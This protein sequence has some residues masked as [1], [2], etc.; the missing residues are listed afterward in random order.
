MSVGHARHRPLAV[1]LVGCGNISATYL[2]HAPL[3]AEAFRIVGVADLDGRTAE[4]AGE[5]Y[6]VPARTVEELLADPAVEAILNLTVPAAHVP[7]ARGAIEAGKHVYVE[8]PL[9]VTVAE[10]TDL[11]AAAAARGLRVGVA[12]DTFLGAAHQTARRLVDEG[13]IGRVVG[14]SAAVMDR[15]MEEWH[16]NPSFFFTKG[17]GPVFD[18]GPYYLASLVDL[19]G[20]AR[21]VS[22]SGL[23]GLRERSIGSGPR[24][25]AAIPIETPTTVNALL[26]FEGGADIVLSASWD[27]WSHRR[28]HLEI[29][30]TQGTLVLPDP[31]WFGG[32]VRLSRH[33]GS[34]EDIL[35]PERPFGRPNRTLGDGSTVAD[36]RGAGLADLAQAIREGRP[37]RAGGTLGLHVLSI[38]EAIETAMRDRT[39]TPVPNPTARP[40]ALHAEPV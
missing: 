14:G 4:A 29:Y 8:K 15:G 36:Y 10:A 16:P 3:F 35:D 37:H 27:V 26:R 20:P 24:K 6:G 18:M 31:N 34:W 2:D 33:G 38:M 28:E 40:E 32:P 30:G 39:E 12:P 7:V 19:L 17:G 5:R 1:G 22:A 21:S 23:I 13:A 9:G 11:L 25:G